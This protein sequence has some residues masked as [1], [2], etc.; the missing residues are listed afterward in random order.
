M[1]RALSHLLN[2]QSSMRLLLHQSNK[3]STAAAAATDGQTLGSV[4]LFIS[5]CMSCT[6]LSMFPLASHA[7][8]LFFQQVASSAISH[9]DLSPS[10]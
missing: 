2:E 9:C 7:F 1:H 3:L 8:F 10:L 5:L 6:T 4:E